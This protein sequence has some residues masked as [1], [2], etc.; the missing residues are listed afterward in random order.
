MF[1]KKKGNGGGKEKKQC[2]TVLSLSLWMQR[3]KE[4]IQLVDCSTSDDI[5]KVYWDYTNKK[6]NSFIK[7]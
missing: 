4:V 5:Q 3:K 7:R 1:E 6:Q 2:K